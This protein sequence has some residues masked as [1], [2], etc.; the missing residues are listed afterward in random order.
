M[1]GF[2][3]TGHGKFASGLLSS[4]YL[5][6]GKPKKVEAVDFLES[7]TMEDLKLKLEKAGQNM[8]ANEM[9]FFTDLMGGSPFKAAVTIA[10]THGSARVIAG[11]NLPMIVENIFARDEGDV[12]DLTNKCLESGRNAI[13][14]F[15]FKKKHYNENHENT[16]G[17]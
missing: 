1:I 13:G 5:I 6:I 16:D 17:I 11:S 12:E 2:I 3:I 7:D 14:K 10:Q 9:I 8:E 4:I 15:E